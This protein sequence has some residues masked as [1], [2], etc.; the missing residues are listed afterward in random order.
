MQCENLAL[1][2]LNRH[3]EIFGYGCEYIVGAPKVHQN[4]GGIGLLLPIVWL[5]AE[6]HPVIN[7]E[8]FFASDNIVLVDMLEA[9]GGVGEVKMCGDGDEVEFAIFHLFVLALEWILQIQ[10]HWKHILH[11]LDDFLPVFAFEHIQQTPKYKSNFSQVCN[12]LGFQVKEDKDEECLWIKFLELEID[13]DKIEARV[14]Q[15]KYENAIMPVDSI[16]EKRSARFKEMETTIGFVS[17]ASKVVP[18]SW[19]FLSSLYDVLTNA[20]RTH[21]IRISL[22]GTIYLKWWRTFLS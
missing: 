13:T 14:L 7:R 15:D 11:Y 17:F 1:K 18:A 10:L 22:H 2:D 16:L 5:I 12:H 4:L 6:G 19:T 8:K 20:P 3:L 21:Y 9:G